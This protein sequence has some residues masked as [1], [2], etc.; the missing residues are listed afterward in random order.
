LVSRET[1]CDKDRIDT[2]DHKQ[3]IIFDEDI[4]KL[5]PSEYMYL[6]YLQTKIGY[7]VDRDVP[8]LSGGSSLQA[9]YRRA[10]DWLYYK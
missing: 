9:L 1:I 6:G 7:N 4:L 2:V 8:R 3:K 5:F 10:E